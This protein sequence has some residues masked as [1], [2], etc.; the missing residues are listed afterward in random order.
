MQ[1]ND[2]LSVKKDERYY[3]VLGATKNNNRIAF[4]AEN[5]TVADAIAKAGG[6][7]GDLAEPGMVVVF[8]REEAKALEGL[9]IKLDG[10]HSDEPIPTVYRLD[11]TEPSGMFLAQKMQL[12]NNDVLYIA[13]HPFT[14]VNKLFSV[15]RD[16]LLLRLITQ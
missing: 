8:R 2:L 5:V 7:N 10:N 3:N 13:A 16:V 6:L 12:R 11:F 14:D 9:D 1:P 15:F 4:E